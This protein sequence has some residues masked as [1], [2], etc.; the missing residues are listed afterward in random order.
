MAVAVAVAV[1]VAA[2]PA[3]PASRVMSVAADLDASMDVAKSLAV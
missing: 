3:V 1:V 2:S